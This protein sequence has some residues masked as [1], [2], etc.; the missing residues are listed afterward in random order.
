MAPHAKKYLHN[1]YVQMSL[2]SRI[3]ISTLTEI[4]GKI[5]YVYVKCNL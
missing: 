4:Q 3:F 5:I 1:I 2:K